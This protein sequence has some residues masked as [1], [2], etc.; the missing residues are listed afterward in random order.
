L[1]EIFLRQEAQPALHG[2]EIQVQF[3]ERA[4]KIKDDRPEFVRLFIDQAGLPVASRPSLSFSLAEPGAVGYFWAARDGLHWSHY[5]TAK[6]G[7]Q[8][9]E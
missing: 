6:D 5:N 8:C 2:R 7:R 3:G 4:I 1:R 9:S